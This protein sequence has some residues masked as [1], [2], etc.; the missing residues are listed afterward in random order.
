MSPS[1]IRLV[2]EIGYIPNMIF[3]IEG[4]HS[5]LIKQHN[6]FLGFTY[7]EIVQVYSQSISFKITVKSFGNVVVNSSVWL[8]MKKFMDFLSATSNLEQGNQ[9]T[10]SKLEAM[11]PGE[12]EL[13]VHKDKLGRCK[14]KYKLHRINGSSEYRAEIVAKQS[15][16]SEDIKRLLRYF[17]KNG[18]YG[19]LISAVNGIQKLNRKE[20]SVITVTTHRTKVY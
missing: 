13:Y 9:E 10:V 16:E 18:K 3:I 6:Q 19:H 8:D 14:V 17:K 11:S 1:T 5:H 15:I 2:H 4:E 20:L 7:K 12:F